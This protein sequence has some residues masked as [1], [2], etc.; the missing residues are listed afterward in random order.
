MKRFFLVVYLLGMCWSR[1]SFAQ[2]VPSGDAAVS[3]V[4]YVPS[5]L[6]RHLTT[7]ISVAT[8]ATTVQIPSL[9]PDVALQ[10][11]KRQAALQAADP[12][13]YSSLTIIHADLSDTFQEADYELQQTFTAPR[14]LQFK[15]VQSSG[16][17]FVKSNV[18]LRLLQSEVNHVEH[19]DPGSTAINAVNYKFSYK[20]RDILQ[21]RL[22]HAFQVKPYKKRSGLFKGY[23]YLD[24]STGALVRSEGKAVRSPSFFVKKI[25][26]VRE[27]A[28]FLSM[29]VPV[30]VHFEARARIVGRAIVDVVYRDY[31]PIT[32]PVN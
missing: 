10:I 32:N 28:N 9:S 1:A 30:H 31:R 17:R 24:A 20:G 2:S 15:A 13:S 21:G 26:F 6:P 7:D 23:V 27:Y 4:P 5:L 25:Q 3:S 22:V 19:D 12:I 8:V 11:Y 14:T 16:D 18:I 29:A